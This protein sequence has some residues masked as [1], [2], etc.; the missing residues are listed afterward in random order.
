VTTFT[1]STWQVFGHDWLLDRLFTKTPS[2]GGLLFDP[3]LRKTATTLMVIKTLRALGEIKRVLVVAPMRVA[4]AEWPGQIVE[5]GFPFSCVFIGGTARQR[6]KALHAPADVHTISRDNLAWLAR[7]HFEPFD[8]IVFDESTSFK[9]WGAIRTKAARHLAPK[10]RM[11]TI[12]TGTP[13]PNHEGDL[14]AQIY[15]L[16]LGEALGKTIT[17]F[18]QQYMRQVG[19]TNYNKWEVVDGKQKTISEAIAHLVL[20]LDAADHLDLPPMLKNV[21]WVDLPPA[22]AKAYKQIERELFAALA[23]GETLTASGAGAKYALCRG[24]ANGGAYVGDKHDRKPVHVH[25]AKIDAVVDLVDELGG[26]PVLIAYQ[27]N[28]DLDR[29]RRKWPKAPVIKGG[30]KPAESSAIVKAWNAGELRVLFGQPQAMSHGLNMQKGP[31]RDIVWVGASDSLET[32]DQLNRRIFRS[33]VTGQVRIHY[34]LARNTVDAAI[35]SRLQDKDARQRSLLDS[36]NAYR[37]GQLTNEWGLA[38]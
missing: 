20:R 10:A 22:I 14:F 38:A 18:R 25:D 9:N 33:G 15:L 4:Y 32:D 13:S 6:L 26:K 8:Y 28:H 36:L 5:H 23:S 34:V 1:P 31:G 17:F 35:W 21:V 7:Q 27:F 2:A 12:L 30:V 37:N 29:L 16:D 24:V 19:P 3:G 11:R